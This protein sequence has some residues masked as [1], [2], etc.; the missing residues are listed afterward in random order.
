MSCEKHPNRDSVANCQFCG[1]ELCEDCT[2][3]IAGKKLL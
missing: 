1:K 3:T 2:I